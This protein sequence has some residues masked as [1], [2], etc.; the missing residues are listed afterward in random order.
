MSIS[1]EFKYESTPY[2][3]ASAKPKKRILI[4]APIRQK[5][6]I[7]TQ[8]LD[9]IAN[10]EVGNFNIE[11][12]FILHNCY[13][14]LKHLFPN[15][16]TLECFEDKTNDVREEI[17]HNW[18]MDN[19]SAVARMKNQIIAHSLKY[20]FD[21]TFFVDS[22]LI[23]HPKTLN[24][25]FTQLEENNE[26]IMAEVFWTE[27]EKGTGVYGSNAWDCDAYVGDQERFKE[28]GIHQV[29]GT[30]ACILINNK[31]YG[32]GVNYNPI[33][34]VSFTYWE[35]RAFCIRAMVNNFKIFLDTNYPAIHLYR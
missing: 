32:Y 30:G 25:L 12:Y 5:P 31:V 14:E 20:K 27:W 17:T 2:P 33:P 3:Y 9:S 8:Y 4:T 21:Y 34:N 15:D 26:N 10:L 6:D 29:G 28:T 19:L 1:S 24:H 35:D 11:K 7:L 16:C 23:L 22:D 18:T 13:E